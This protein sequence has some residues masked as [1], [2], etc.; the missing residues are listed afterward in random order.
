MSRREQVQNAMHIDIDGYFRIGV[1]AEAELKARYK[2]TREAYA[3]YATHS[4]ESVRELVTQYY[5]LVRSSFVLTNDKI[6]DKE[7]AQ[8]TLNRW[9]R[10]SLG[11][12]IAL[13]DYHIHHARIPQ[14]DWI[15]IAKIAVLNAI[16]EEHSSLHSV[17]LTAVMEPRFSARASANG[18]IRISSFTY[19][20]LKA[21]NTSVVLAIYDA[22]DDQGKISLNSG[23]A[24]SMLGRYALPHYVYL[25]DCLSTAILPYSSMPSV[26]AYQSVI[27]LTNMQI[28]LILAHEYAHIA[29]GHHDSPAMDKAERDQQEAEA[30]KFAYDACCRLAETEDGYDESDVWNA[31]RFLYQYQIT[32]EVV[33]RLLRREEFNLDEFE[34]EFE[35]RR[36]AILKGIIQQKQPLEGVGNTLELYGTLLL[37]TLKQRLVELGGDFVNGVADL[38]EEAPKKGSIEPWWEK[39]QTGDS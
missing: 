7:E 1:E 16:G 37:L 9:Q 20:V 35:N 24:V 32:S 14:P 36:S 23:L 30:D 31:Y 3:K 8:K 33:L 38:L 5:W 12:A 15:D 13:T 22:L 17:A 21:L 34:F 19:G 4:D 28:N 11:M 25:H 27:S 2:N 6:K 26:E 10:A 39:L 29:L 18:S